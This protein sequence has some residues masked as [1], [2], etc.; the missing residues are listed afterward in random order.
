MSR[1]KQSN[2]KPLK[3]DLAH[4]GLPVEYPTTEERKGEAKDW[5]ERPVESSPLE[6]APSSGNGRN[7]VTV[8]EA[9][10][11][12]SESPDRPNSDDDRKSP[13]KVESEEKQPRIRLKA[14]LAT[15]PALTMLG[16]IKNEI[17]PPTPTPEY[18]S[19]LAPA[20]QS[21][22]ASRALLFPT[23][24]N[25]NEAVAAVAAAQRVATSETVRVAEA[26]TASETSRPSVPVYQCAP[27]GIRF[28][29]LSTLEAHQTYYCSHRP[30]KPS[31]DD[32]KAPGSNSD[33]S[34]Q[35]DADGDS[36]NKN[37][38]TTK[39]YT[40]PHCSYSADKKV[41]L[42]RHMRM[43]TSSPGPVNS[44]VPSASTSSGVSNGEASGSEAQDRYCAECDI[45]F[46][47]QKTYRAHKMHYCNSRHVVKQTAPA[48][49]CTSGSSPTS[50]SDPATC[51]TPPSPTP[52]LQPQ[53]PFLALPTNPIIIVPY[54]LFR[55][56]SVLPS[57][58][59]ATG[60]PSPDTPCFLLPN[61]TLQPM[62]SALSGINIGSLPQMPQPA[63]AG[64]E[65]V[66]KTA[67]KGNKVSSPAKENSSTPL[68]LTV[69]KSTELK[70]RNRNGT[71]ESM[72][73]DADHEKENMKQRSFTPEKIECEPLIHGSPCSTPGIL[74]DKSSPG[75]SISPKR[76]LDD[77]SRSN[78]PRSS[79]TPKLSNDLNSV[80]PEAG[81][82]IGQQFD[83]PSALHPLLMRAGTLPLFTPELQRRLSDLPP[84][85]PVMPQVIVKQ[86]VSKCKECNIVFCKLENYVVHKKHYC[87]ARTLEDD[88]S[89]TSGSPPVSPRS[90]G[91]TS[92]AAQYQQLICLACGIKFTSPDNLNAHQQYYCLKR[93]DLEPKKCLKCRAVVEP[94]H[95][96]VSHTAL[97][98]WKCPC[99]D[100][101]SPTGSAAQR[102]METHTGVKAYRCTICKYKGNTLRGMKTHIR[103]H[104]D[105]R[106]PDLQEEKYITY[107]LEDETLG[108]GI[109]EVAIAPH[110]PT[111]DRT[112]PSSENRPEPQHSCPQCP[113]SS[114][115]KANVVRHIKLVHDVNNIE[116]HLS[117]GDEKGATKNIPQLE[118][119]EEI[120]VKKEAIEPE[121]IIAPIE[122]ATIKE[123]P[124]LSSTPKSKT[125]DEEI[126]QEAAKTG[127]NYCKSCDIYFNYLST[128]IAHK[129]FYCSSHA[130]EITSANNNNNTATRPTE[131]S[132][133]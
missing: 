6:T 104:F 67:N 33:P 73:I 116:E 92:P 90:G 38:R 117:N 9:P 62:T 72:D 46:S 88:S 132:V 21:A 97:A 14:G 22:L 80:S 8:L 16:T 42:N 24:L 101:I 126:M 81:L 1:R 54:S 110:L 55:S 51:R 91:T 47:S 98:G 26:A 20:I 17:E 82:P 123:E 125:S 77:L 11:K 66:L 28:S 108:P 29:S 3:S 89:K 59:T 130:G 115:Y 107:I 60:I 30:N 45:R 64:A 84:L 58:S 27:C 71:P 113:Y 32:P 61:G 34:S 40:C 37:L 4:E 53:Q 7:M 57:L 48:S 86:G 102:H 131:T 96:C 10:P 118:E 109:S 124:E 50:P 13:T 78:S 114:P 95:Q 79:K 52:S 122:G 70:E 111:D 23:S 85:P 112:S 69:R 63:Q 83:I 93:S 105:K 19:S 44:A 127:P 2:P 41:S 87:S 75:L 49:S 129:K 133:L 103:V 36:V 31:D 18:L 15:D 120:I 76:K 99:C 94:G 5:T 39:Q 119:E 65:Q 121:V 74:A 35:S 56:A 43:H 100:V 12:K 25:L 128:F 106:S 68:D